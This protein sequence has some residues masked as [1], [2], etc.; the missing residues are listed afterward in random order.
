MIELSPGV[1]FNPNEI[2]CNQVEQSGL[3]IWRG[4]KINIA[5][6]NCKQLLQVDVCSRVIRI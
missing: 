6:Y 4:F 3:K 1:F 5:V 2:D